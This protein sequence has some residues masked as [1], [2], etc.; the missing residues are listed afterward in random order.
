MAR[1]P[2]FSVHQ[3]EKRL[4]TTLQCKTYCP[5]IS[6]GACTPVS[7]CLLWAGQGTGHYHKLK[8]RLFP[9]TRPARIC[10][11]EHTG[12]VTQRKSGSQHVIVLADQYKKLM[13]AIQFTTVTSTSTV[14]V[15]VDNWAGLLRGSR[16]LTDW[17][18]TAVLVQVLLASYCPSEP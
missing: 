18:R 15:I 9:G 4:Y 17:K 12:S 5:H 10:G 6:D 3:R 7:D 11:D 16:T 14:T 2:G 13:W 8:L 1:Y